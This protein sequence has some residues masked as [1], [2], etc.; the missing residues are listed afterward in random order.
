LLPADFALRGRIESE[1][2][3]L[4]VLSEGVITSYSGEL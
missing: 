4:R 2:I 3:R 1:K